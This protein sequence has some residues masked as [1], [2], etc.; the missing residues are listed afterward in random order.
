MVSQRSPGA[1]LLPAFDEYLV[2]YRD[3]SALID[4]AYVR[5]VNA[6]GGMLSPAVVIDGRVVARRPDPG[7]AL[8]AP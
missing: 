3:R 1:H 8:P 7:T 4:P 6:G 5:K 2:G